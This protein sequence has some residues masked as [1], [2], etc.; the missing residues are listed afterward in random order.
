MNS[1][2][3]GPGDIAKLARH[4]QSVIC[5][6]IAFVEQQFIANHLLKVLSHPVDIVD[7]EII[8]KC[9]SKTLLT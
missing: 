3:I 5:Q 7:S 2:S 9:V 8:L 6:A 4:K 1:V